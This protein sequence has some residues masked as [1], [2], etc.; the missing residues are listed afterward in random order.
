MVV[1]QRRGDL[2]G[3]AIFSSQMQVARLRSTLI[4][5]IGGLMVIAV[6]FGMTLFFLQ[7][8]TRTV[9]DC[10][11]DELLALKPPF[12]Q[13]GGKAFVARMQVP[14]GDSNQQPARSTIV[15]CEDEKR[16]GPGHSLHDDIRGKGLGR[17]S[18]W[19][20]DVIFSA[21]DN[22]D[23]NTNHRRYSYLPIAHQQ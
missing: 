2:T 10:K 8:S 9:D 20:F 21:S 14:D 12:E 4:K 16:L 18:H 22:S 7:R 11:S 13:Y 6:S 15:L 3:T 23:P 19:G 5:V 17:Y 1:L